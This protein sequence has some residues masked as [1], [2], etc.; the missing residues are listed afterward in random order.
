MFFRNCLYFPG[1]YK[2]DWKFFGGVNVT[3]FK[4]KWGGED[5]EMVDRVLTKGLEIE[6]LRLPHFYHFYHDRTGLWEKGK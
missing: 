1:T 3:G 4:Y 5:S 2:S 6:R